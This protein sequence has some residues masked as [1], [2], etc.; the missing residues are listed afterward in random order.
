M[1]DPN[2]PDQVA[3]RFV[4][5]DVHKASVM[6]GAVN[7]GQETVLPPHRVALIDFDGWIA[8]H[9]RASDA[10]ALEASGSAWDIYD[11]LV[12]HVERVTVVHPRLVRLI[13]ASPVKTDA[14]DALTLARLLAANLLPSVWVPPPPVRELR[15]LVAHRRRLIGQRT[16]ARN[17]LHSILHRHNLVAP[18]RSPFAAEQRGWWEDLLLD[19]TEKLRVRQDLALLTTLAGLLTEV[20]DELGRLSRA[21]PW[22][23]QVPFLVQVPGISLLSAMTLLAAIGEIDRFPTAK[24]LVGYAGLGASVHASG[25]RH[26]TGGITKQ[27]RR[28]LRTCLVEGAWRA[29]ETNPLWKAIFQKLTQRMSEPQAIVAIARKLLVV[30]WHVL[31]ERV[32]DRHAEAEVVARKLF[33]WGAQ[34]RREDRAMPLAAF[35]RAGLERLKL[36]EDLTSFHRSPRGPLVSLPPATAGAAKALAS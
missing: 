35:T 6:V 1:D 26:T 28:D 8:K 34:I 15:A 22:A 5:L 14:R 4:G 16:Q 2:T 20:E 29:V 11:R 17:R 13:G 7:A 25:Q 18:G 33:N 23:D 36:G 21:E 27:G 24:H 31:K 30:V 19:P 32:A 10:V 12:G 9:L 3:P